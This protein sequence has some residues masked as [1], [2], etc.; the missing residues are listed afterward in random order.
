[1]ICK[2]TK[3]WLLLSNDNWLGQTLLK[4][5]KEPAAVLFKNEICHCHRPT[6]HHRSCDPEEVI[7]DGQSVGLSVK[8]SLRI[9]FPQA[10]IH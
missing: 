7:P 2:I 8:V 10:V 5:K 6:E 3:Q 4:Q 9:V 1:M